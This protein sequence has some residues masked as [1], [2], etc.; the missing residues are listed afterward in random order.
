MQ[1]P[2][3]DALR[4]LDALDTKAY[5]VRQEM[6]DIPEDLAKWKRALEDAKGKHL[7]NHQEQNRCQQEIHKLTLETK[8]NQ[9]TITK[10]QVQQNQVKTNEEYSQLKKQMEA[11]RKANG[12]LD[13]KQ[14]AL[15]EKIDQ[16]K[17]AEKGLKA[18]V[19]LAEEKLGLE[20][21]EAKEE[22][23]KLK[24]QLDEILA[25]RKRIE[26][27]VSPG[28]LQLYRR[29]LDKLGRRALAQVQG[30][31]CQGCFIEL[32]PQNVNMLLSGKEV[33][34]CPQCARILF[35]ERDYKAVT[36]LSYTVGE[37]DRDST[38]KDGNW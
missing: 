9:D 17:E 23:A 38:S 33:V 32:S 22:E 3:I 5:R 10:Y 14:L 12:D 34:S 15:Y 11:L 27:G 31:T 30:R 4:Q 13:D 8:A 37:K 25:E 19:K 20:A 16:L 26:G 35:L 21:A 1:N 7:A 18:G 24:K 29:V 6:A 28:T 36:S 2:E